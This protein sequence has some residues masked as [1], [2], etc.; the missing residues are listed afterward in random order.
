MA[1]PRVVGLLLRPVGYVV[2]LLWCTAV[3]A[4]LS[5]VS[6]VRLG[7]LALSGARGLLPIRS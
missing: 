1:P 3:G 7:R 6:M 5:V 2:F 4:A